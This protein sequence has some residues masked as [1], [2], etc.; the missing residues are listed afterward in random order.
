M[1]NRSLLTTPEH[2]VGGYRAFTPPEDLAFVVEAAWTHHAVTSDV[3]H[4]VV[5][6]PAISLCYS[7]VDELKLCLIG[8]VGRARMFEPQVGHRM[9]AIRIKIEWCRAL[10]GI[11]P[12]EHED[13]VRAYAD[14]LPRLARILE[15]RLARTSRS[16]EALGILLEFAR[17]RT[18]TLSNARTPWVVRAGMEMLRAQPT[19]VRLR[20]I[21]AKLG[22]SDRHLRRTIG[23]ETG[24]SPRRFARMQRF[25]AL[26]RDADSAPRPA[27]SMLAAKHR[28]ADQAHLIHEVQE[29][30]GVTPAR[31]VEERRAESRAPVFELRD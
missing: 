2:E 14:T 9:S 1:A 5:P 19:E 3:R 17:E 25:H 27:W 8:P 13:A 30:A 20:T 7:G 15:D 16:D 11:D 6:D 26:L 22:V 24:I 10:L 12:Y 23:A 18:A 4:R 28:Y 21:S 29:L 31:L